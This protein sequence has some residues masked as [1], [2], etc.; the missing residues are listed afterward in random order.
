MYEA[1][2]C[3]CRVCACSRSVAHA[4]EV[5]RLYPPVA[6]GQLRVAWGQDITLAGRL[7]LPAG[8]AVWV[9]HQ[10][11]QTASFNWDA[12]DRFLPGAQA[13]APAI[14]SQSL[15]SPPMLRLPGSV[16]VG[17]WQSCC[18]LG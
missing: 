9:P 16:Q 14:S 6:V 10:A 7:H 8:T 1:G 4:Q 17:W 15:L 5:L 11:I 13:P 12:H 3:E 18:H 2:V